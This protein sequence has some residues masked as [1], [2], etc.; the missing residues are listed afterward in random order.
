MGVEVFDPDCA[1]AVFG[2]GNL[3][4]GGD[5]GQGR[6]VGRRVKAASCNKYL[7]SKFWS[8]SHPISTSPRTREERGRIR[9]NS[10]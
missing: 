3:D 7:N 9:P 5:L 4:G 1:V 8:K 2:T 6:L 10:A